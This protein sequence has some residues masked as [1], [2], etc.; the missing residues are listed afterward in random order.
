LLNIGEIHDVKTVKAT[1]QAVRKSGVMTHLTNGIVANFCGNIKLTLP[2]SASVSKNPW[3]YERQLIITPNS[4]TEFS[5]AGDSGSLVM[6]DDGY[7]VGLLVGG[8]RDAEALTPRSVATP[9][10]EVLEQ[11]R[12]KLNPRPSK[13]ELICYP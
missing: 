12:R 1:G 4:A 5:K 2:G 3:L 9:I 11:L 10:K 7:A 13:L 8:G 6:T